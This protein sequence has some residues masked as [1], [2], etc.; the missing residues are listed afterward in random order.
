MDEHADD[1]M[2]C[3]PHAIQNAKRMLDVRRLT[4]EDVEVNIADSDQVIWASVRGESTLVVFVTD[5]H[6]KSF[7]AIHEYAAAQSINHVIVA[8]Q[9][10]CTPMAS[11]DLQTAGFEL[12]KMKE[13]VVFPL[14]SHLVP[15][16]TLLADEEAA[17]VRKKFDATRLPAIYTTDRVQRIFAGKVNDIYQIVARFGALQSE[18]KYRVVR[19]PST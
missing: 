4:G 3:L 12:F 9:N 8:Y 16:Y 7:T 17:E 10:K 5:V 13:L 14:D 19:E 1:G 11:K 2:A 6:K 15:E 18:V